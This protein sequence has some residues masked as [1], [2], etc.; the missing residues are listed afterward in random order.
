[1]AVA[2]ATLHRKNGFFIIKEGWE[3]TS[4]IGVVALCVAT[5][6]PGEWSLDHAL[7]IDDNLRGWAGLWISALVGLGSAAALLAVFYRPPEPA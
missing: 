5:L 2:I 6:G 4:L 7:E 3:Y 1:M